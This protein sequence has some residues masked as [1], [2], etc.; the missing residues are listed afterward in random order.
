MICWIGY[1]YE[2]CLNM[3]II[4]LSTDI[5]G[6]YKLWGTANTSKSMSYTVHAFYLAQ[7]SFMSSSLS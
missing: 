4:T 3:I 5:C 2:L 7:S 6:K 1:S